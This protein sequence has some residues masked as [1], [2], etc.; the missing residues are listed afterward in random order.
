MC[1]VGSAYVTMCF[2]HIC[3]EQ[4]TEQLRK[5]AYSEFV[6]LRRLANCS[7]IPLSSVS[8][9]F[10]GEASPSNRFGAIATWM[11]WLGLCVRPMQTKKQRSSNRNQSQSTTHW[12]SAL[13]ICLCIEIFGM[14]FYSIG[15]CT[16]PLSDEAYDSTYSHTSHASHYR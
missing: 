11:G 16:G 12:S 5:I 15:S 13:Q 1:T 4:L 8:S 3:H 10:D 14:R 2:W 9:A 6:C 7:S